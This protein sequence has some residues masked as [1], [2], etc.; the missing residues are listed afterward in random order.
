MADGDRCALFALLRLNLFS[1][2]AKKARDR[3]HTPPER[4]YVAGNDLCLSHNRMAGRTAP[5]ASQTCRAHGL[6]PPLR[7]APRPRL[8]PAG[9]VSRAVGGTGCPTRAA[10]GAGEAGRR[11][12]VRSQAQARARRRPR[13]RT[14]PSPTAAGACESSRLPC[15][16]SCRTGGRGVERG[17]A[18]RRRRGAGAGAERQGPPCRASGGS[19][20][21]KCAEPFDAA[22]V[23]AHVGVS[24]AA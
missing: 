12:Q 24:D 4:V 19:G 21:Q 10:G 6:A 22:A 2:L 13:P 17:G 8:R 16:G 20:V 18:V 15:P 9:G 1:G 14:P 23:G 3:S 11:T 7:P 5:V